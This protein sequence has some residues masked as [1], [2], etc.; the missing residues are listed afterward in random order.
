MKWLFFILL[1]ANLGM[2]IL[3]YP[4]KAENIV[5]K[6]LPDVGELYLFQEI[7]EM[8]T[9]TSAVEAAPLTEKEQPESDQVLQSNADQTETQAV[10]QPEAPSEAPESVAASVPEASSA[11]AEIAIE[12]EV[13]APVIDGATAGKTAEVEPPV[14]R[15][16][17]FLDTRSEAEIISVSLRALGLK[18]DLQSETS[19]QQAGFWVLIPPQASRRDAIDISNRLEKDGVSDLW[20]FTSGDL[21]HAIS[22]GLFRNKERAEARNKEITAL[23]YEVIVKP[24]YRQKTK[25]WLYF[26]DST[27]AS[28]TKPGWIELF[29]KFPDLEA[30]ETACR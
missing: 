24:R 13:E 26:Q 23:G 2:F 1:L 8:E 27:P 17:G 11:E 28:D 19:N 22:L 14:C 29:R 20:R 16:V 6:T 12:P 18:P 4:Q 21:V 7:A 30:Q 10:E 25:Y 9:D 5:E 3:I 15:T